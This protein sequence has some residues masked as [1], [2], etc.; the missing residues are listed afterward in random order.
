MHSR[1]QRLF[2]EV[3]HSTWCQIILDELTKFVEKSIKCAESIIFAKLND[4][5]K[6]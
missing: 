6:S 2:T 3:D 5:I 1:I 4:A